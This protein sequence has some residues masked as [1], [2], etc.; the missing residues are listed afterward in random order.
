MSTLLRAFQ[1]IE[2]EQSAP[3]LAAPTSTTGLLLAARSET[4]P[5]IVVTA[6]SRR[7]DELKDELETYLGAGSVV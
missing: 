4:S 3:H 6:S 5:L 2:I 1:G 7:A